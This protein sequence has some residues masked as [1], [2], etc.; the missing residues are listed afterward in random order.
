MAFS[1]SPKIVTDGLV[2]CLDAANTKSY[3]G[4]G[5]EVFNLANTSYSGSFVNMDSTN[6]ANGYLEFDGVNERIDFPS[7]TLDPEWTIMYFFYHNSA[8][9]FDMTVGKYN[10]TG[11]RFYHRD[12]GTDYRLRVHNNDNT[13][14]ADLIIGDKRQ[15]WAFLAYSMKDN[16]GTSIVKGWVNG[17]NALSTTVSDNAEFIFNTVGFPY[18]S[19]DFHWLGNIGPLLIYS[20]QLIDSEVLQ[21]Y[22]ALKGRYGL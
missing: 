9:N 7:L 2:L 12:T 16:G 5:T 3:A 15:Q 6:A 17:I 1:H 19:T 8:S 13:S 11:N 4:S 14:V 18:T 22:N 21:N 10:N 20:R